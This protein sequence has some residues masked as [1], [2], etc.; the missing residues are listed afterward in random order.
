MKR[1]M[2]A[3]ALALLATGAAAQ[4]RT[5]TGIADHVMKDTTCQQVMDAARKDGEPTSEPNPIVTLPLMAI[6]AAALGAGLGD[7]SD[8][9]VTCRPAA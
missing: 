2:L 1:P 7:P 6:T 4:D 5:P 8:M 3:A 9:R